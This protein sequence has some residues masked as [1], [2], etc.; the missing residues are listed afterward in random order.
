MEAFYSLLQHLRQRKDI[1]STSRT[2]FLGE[3]QYQNS[4]LLT[5]A[6]FLWKIMSQTL[7][8]PCLQY[9]QTAQWFSWLNYLGILWQVC[10]AGL[11]E[12]L[13]QEIVEYSLILGQI[14]QPK[15]FQKCWN[16]KGG[17]F[18][19]HRLAFRLILELYRKMIE[20]DR[21]SED[22]WLVDSKLGMSQVSIEKRTLWQEWNKEFICWI[23]IIPTKF[24][25][26]GSSC[27]SAAPAKV[28]AKKECCCILHIRMNT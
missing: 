9:P 5:I 8:L 13:F 18:K 25:L 21:M 23:I 20:I 11:P 6:L 22:E 2:S 14:Y 10:P 15:L 27:E 4:E 1:F 16:M 26:S 12:W 7:F 17:C 28:F 3:D 19:K 24:R